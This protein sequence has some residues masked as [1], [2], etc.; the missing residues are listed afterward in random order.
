MLRSRNCE[1]AVAVLKLGYVGN[2]AGNPENLISLILRGGKRP[3][4]EPCVTTID[5][6]MP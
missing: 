6:R 3:E 4:K 5:T 2:S 1:R